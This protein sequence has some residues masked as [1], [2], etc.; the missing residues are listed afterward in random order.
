M[1]DL[2]NIRNVV[3]HE[4]EQIVQE[5]T[6]FQNHLLSQIEDTCGIFYQSLHLH[7]DLCW[8]DYNQMCKIVNQQ[9]FFFA[10]KLQYSHL[11]SEREIRLCV[12]VLIGITNSKQLADMLLYSESGIRNFKN[13]TAKKLDTNSVELRN[14]LLKIAIGQ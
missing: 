13:R 10:Q 8:S 7:K 14:K 12:L 11:L 3:K 6:E 5:H 1:D 4:H 2:K 9:F